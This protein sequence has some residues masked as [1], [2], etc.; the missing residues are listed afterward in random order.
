MYRHDFVILDSKAVDPLVVKWFD[1]FASVM[2]KDYST[3]VVFRAL[4]S[5]LSG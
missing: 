2:F 5:E 4:S 1:F 3:M